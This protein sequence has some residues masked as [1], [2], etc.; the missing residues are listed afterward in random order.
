[1]KKITSSIIG[2]LFLIGVLGIVALFTGNTNFTLANDQSGKE[3]DVPLLITNQIENYSQLNDSSPEMG[4]L[5]E[6]IAKEVKELSQQ[7]HDAN[8]MAGWIHIVSRWQ[9]DYDEI[10]V[11]PNGKIMENEFVNDEWYLLDEQ[12]Q[13]KKQVLIQR[14]INGDV[15]QVSALRD[16]TGY[17]LT[18]GIKMSMPDE[19]FEFVWDFGF[20]REAIRLAGS[21]EKEIISLEGKTCVLYT[22]TEENL[23]PI[24]ISEYNEPVIAIKTRACFEPDS[25]KM[26]FSDRVVIMSSGAERINPSVKLVSWETGVQPPTEVS[27]YLDATYENTFIHPSEINY[28]PTQEV[29][30]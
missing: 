4:E 13:I 15:I 11:A 29:T 25:G 12:G 18:Y 28:N 26:L 1:M 21:I 9:L 27:T 30:Q 19:A 17:N 10:S 8:K 24:T 23:S 7:W 5:G 20:P 16:N 14:D 22:V 2:L 3:Q 6:N